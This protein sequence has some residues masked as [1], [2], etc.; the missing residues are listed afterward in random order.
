MNKFYVM[1]K[2]K[3]YTLLLL[4]VALLTACDKKIEEEPE[5]YGDWDFM[6]FSIFLYAT[7]GTNNLFDPAFNG[8]ICQSV[9]VTYNG[10]EYFWKPQSSSR[11]KLVGYV[12]KGLQLEQSEDGYY[13]SFGQISRDFDDINLKF[14]V[15]WPDGKKDTIEYRLTRRWSNRMPTTT[16]II[17]LNGKPTDNLIVTRNLYFN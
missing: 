12:F 1:K 14:V 6:P 2:S 15:N 10:Q 17:L 7:D 4:I 3:L 5:D 13:M 8:N 9:S 16:E 11:R